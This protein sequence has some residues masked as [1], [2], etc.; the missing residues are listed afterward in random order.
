MR[1]DQCIVMCAISTGRILAL[2]L[3]DLFW[4]KIM[5]NFTY[6]FLVFL[7]SASLA[8]DHHQEVN[9]LGEF[10]QPFLPCLEFSTIE[11]AVLKIPTNSSHTY[12]IFDRLNQFLTCEPMGISPRLNYFPGNCTFTGNFTGIVKT[13]TAI[14]TNQMAGFLKWGL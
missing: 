3:L 2:G 12:G 9:I 11:I 4:K 8:F 7:L 13:M 14:S 6:S 10:L 5:E 1:N